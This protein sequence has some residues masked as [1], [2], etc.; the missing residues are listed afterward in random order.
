[1]KKTGERLEEI[2]HVVCHQANSR[3]I[4]NVVRHLKAEPGQFFE[5]MELYGNTSGASIPIAL[6]DMEEQGLL[7]TGEKL[8]LIG[9]GAGLTFGAV[10]IVYGKNTEKK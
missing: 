9:F 8:L 1:M 3:I 10:E 4:R 5:D 2:D 6:K 7:K